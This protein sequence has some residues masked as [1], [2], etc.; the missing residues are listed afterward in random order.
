VAINADVRFV[1]GARV[2]GD[3]IVVGGSVH[4]DDGVTI[5]GETRVQAELLR[6]TLDGDRIEPEGF[7]PGE[8]RPRIGDGDAG[9]RAY[10]D[11]FFIAARTYNRV[12]G[13]PV[14]IGPRF[15]RTTD[16]GRIDVDAL[17]VVRI[18]EP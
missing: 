3:V 5:S 9:R 11:L 10:T 15:R 4:R 17:G 1:R 8:W 6:Y 18:A 16:W 14:L 13:L 7:V 2:S 12:E